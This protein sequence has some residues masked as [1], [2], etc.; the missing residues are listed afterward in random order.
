ME[1]KE[2]HEITV[3][4]NGENRP[5]IKPERIV[6]IT[7]EVGYWRKFNGLHGWFVENV[8]GGED[9]C[10]EYRVPLEKLEEL[11]ETMK[12]L[13]LNRGKEEVGKNLLPTQEGFFFGSTSY[14]EYYWGDV[15][16]T[17]EILED[18]INDK[19]GEFFY[20]SSW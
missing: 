5:D 10:G 6:F 2:R 13:R 19:D 11:L 17:I 12:I 1:P 20:H 18:C 7:E 9:D 14:D 4:L 3:K 16:N 8:Q 15:E